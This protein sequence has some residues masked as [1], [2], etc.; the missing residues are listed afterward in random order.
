MADVSDLTHQ[1]KQRYYE[2]Q[3]Q[4]R[5]SAKA[6]AAAAKASAV[7]TAE[8]KQLNQTSAR[9]QA[10]NKELVEIQSRALDEASRQ[11]NLIE[12]QLHISKIAELEKNRQI[13]LKQAA[14]AINEEVENILTFTSQEKQYVHLRFQQMQVDAVG[15]SPSEAQEISDK[16]Y[17]KDVVGK[18][19]KGVEGLES[20]LAP[21]IIQ[22]TNNFFS[23]LIEAG[24]LQYELQSLNA[25]LAGLSGHE[26]G[27]LPGMV[28]QGLV[29]PAGVIK[30]IQNTE[31]QQKFSQNV[32][33]TVNLVYYFGVFS[34][35]GLVAIV[36]AGLGWS[37]FNKSAKEHDAVLAEIA[38]VQDSI[39]MFNT[40]FKAAQSLESTFRSR[41]EL[42]A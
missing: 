34:T 3:D 10:L 8:L 13:E 2:K 7:Q 11:T 12:A 39:Q 17:I 21:Q 31:M 30:S 40:K 32:V 38:R 37:K 27:S 18:I 20:K 15:L 36:G 41:Y 42:L 22:E 29:N 14:F 33:V 23:A 26:K 28:V 35:M 9:L 16:N 6:S 4:M 19:N 5:A 1:E 24:E 25:R